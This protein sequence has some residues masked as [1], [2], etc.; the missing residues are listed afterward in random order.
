M[1]LADIYSKK[2]EQERKWEGKATV[3]AKPMVK[4]VHNTLQQKSWIPL[5]QFK[6]TELPMCGSP[7][8]I[9]KENIGLSFERDRQK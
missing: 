4:D 5:E 3:H 8:N 1:I 6:L 2:K 7:L 9:E